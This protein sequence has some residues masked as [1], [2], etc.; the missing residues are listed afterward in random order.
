[1]DISDWSI[2]DWFARLL[3]VGIIFK[4]LRLAFSEKEIK[5]YTRRLFKAPRES[6]ATPRQRTVLRVAGVFGIFLGTAAVI[7]GAGILDVL[8]PWIP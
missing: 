6:V 2:N 7:Y 4:A 1:M 3:G 8:F 5:I